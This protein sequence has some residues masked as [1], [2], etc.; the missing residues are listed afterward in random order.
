MQGANGSRTSLGIVLLTNYM[1][2]EYILTRLSERDHRLR[3]AI[4]KELT[5][6]KAIAIAM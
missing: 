6:P 1:M 2:L 3:D 4:Y 5:I